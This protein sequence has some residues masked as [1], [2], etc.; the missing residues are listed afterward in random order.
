MMEP[1]KMNDEAFANDYV[2][3]RASVRLR[4]IANCKRRPHGMGCPCSCEGRLDTCEDAMIQA[5]FQL[6]REHERERFVRA[7]SPAQMRAAR[8]SAVALGDELHVDPAPA[9]AAGICGTDDGGGFKEAPKPGSRSAG[10]FIEACGNDFLVIGRSG[11]GLRI[12]VIRFNTEGTNRIYCG[13][14][15]TADQAHEIASFINAH[16]GVVK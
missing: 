3:N 4:A 5:A 16:A 13:T 15:V 1:T 7:P 12:A 11:R 2:V 14:V 10:L 8:P 6:G 9:A